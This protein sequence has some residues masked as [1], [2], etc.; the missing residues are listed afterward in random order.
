MAKIEIPKQSIPTV[1]SA[2]ADVIGTTDN[3]IVEIK[4]EL[5][6]EDNNQKFQIH[7]DTIEQLADRITK[8]G[9]LSPC[10]VTPLPD[11]KYELIDGRHRR[12]AVIK[13]GLP[14]TKCII[15][16]NLSDKEKKTIR[17]TS[18]LARNN[19]YLPSELAFA[20]KELA[21]LEDLKTISEETSLSKKK[22]YRYIRLT[23]LIEPLLSRVDSGSIPVIA[24]VELSYLTVQQQKTLFEFLLNHSDCKITTTNAREIKEKP[25]I[26]D[27]VF[28]E[29][30]E[31][32]IIETQDK[33]TKIETVT[34]QV[35][36][37]STNEAVNEKPENN[38]NDTVVK[39]SSNALIENGQGEML[40]VND[41]DQEMLNIICE[42]VIQY[43]NIDYCIIKKVYDSREVINY[44]NERYIKTY[45]R[46]WGSIFAGKRIT[47]DWH[48]TGRKF[49]MIIGEKVFIMPHKVLES[50]IRQYIRDYYDTKRIISIIQKEDD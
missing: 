37:L 46:C 36:N 6:I 26:L 40:S 10:I 2:Y 8:D 22:I 12:R 27:E 19:D 23:N 33:P 24:A 49:R 35:D 14:T 29:P 34:K 9:Q 43:T 17:L 5:I 11:G 48:Y 41:I 39:T 44:F 38:T 47:I 28:L 20:Y 15:K 50:I 25:D 18:N 30:T 45:S 31:K 1:A 16:G 4:N 21:E 42:Y 13:A 3:Q 32:E 7:E